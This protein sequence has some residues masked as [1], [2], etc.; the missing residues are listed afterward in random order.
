VTQA[1]GGLDLIALGEWMGRALGDVTKARVER[2]SPAASGYSAQTD[3]FELRYERDGVAH[4]DKFV[5]RR[6]TPERPIYPTQVPGLE[7][8]TDIQYRAMS[9]L[10][11]AADIPLA[12]LVGY[13]PDPSALGSPFFV[14]GHVEGEVPRE[15]PIYTSEGMFVDAAP[16]Q[17]RSMV[18]QGLR[19]MAAI[20]AVDVAE[21]GF[22]W[23]VPAGV[24]PGTAHQL[25]LWEGFGR[26]ELGER[27]HPVFE[28]GVAW[29]ERNLPADS[30]LVVN[31]GDPRL[32]NIIW[33]EHRAVC[34]TDFENVSI[35]SPEQD[36]GWWLLFDRWSHE[37]AGVPRLEGEPTRAEQVEIY[38]ELSGRRLRDVAFYEVFAGLRY[39]AI[40]V[41][42]MNR[43][44]DRGEMPADTTAW[45][46][47]PVATTLASLL[48]EVG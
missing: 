38:E 11:R 8:E 2:L 35:A 42:V 46:D 16:D 1:G 25:R 47:N 41:R 29:L 12:P 26:R 44:V 10:A 13:E 43:Y 6:E 48:D 4:D 32:G 9:A 19:A 21:A 18:E 45:R 24:S 23:L 34:V 30:G 37:G 14:M 3:V 5:L 36:V 31:W 27:E 40:V 28:R 15:S 17:R 33:R 20:H 7:V 39:T 22:D